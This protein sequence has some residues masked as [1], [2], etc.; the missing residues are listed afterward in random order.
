MV[1][2]KKSIL[3][4]ILLAGLLTAT[5]VFADDSNN[6]VQLDLKRASDSSVDVTLVT[7][8]NYGDNVMVR[9]KSDT[10][11]VI[12][13]PKVK[14]AGYRASNLTGVNDLVS[15]VD[16]KTVED[17]SGGYTKVTLITTRPLDIK[18]RTQKTNVSSSDRKEYNSLMAQANAVKNNVSKYEPPKQAQQKT[19]ITVNKTPNVSAKDNSKKAA[20]QQKP[21]IKLTEITPDKIEKQAKKQAKPN[22]LAQ[23][24]QEKALEELPKALPEIP[25]ILKNEND[26]TSDMP[27]EPI[28]TTNNSFNLKA[29]LAALY[30]KAA[31]KIPSKL[32]KAL[33]VG[34][35]ALITVSALAKLFGRV[36]SQTVLENPTQTFMDNISKAHLP[37]E[38]QTYDDYVTS[39]DLSWREKY[40][41]YLDKNAQP[42]KRANKKGHYSFIKMPAK[43]D[44]EKKRQ[45]LEKLV[46]K[47]EVT[48]Q[49]EHDFI[50]NVISEDT[51]ISRTVKFKA[52][53][54]KTNSLRM[55]S[56]DKSRF[57]GYETRL[58]LHELPNVDLEDSPLASN[59][60][61]LSGANLKVSDVDKRKI[62]YEP[63]EYIMSSVDEYLSILD[64][65]KEDKL[66]K[67][68]SY[69]EIS[70]KEEHMAKPVKAEKPEFLQGTV[71]KSGYKISPEKGIYM[72][73]KNGK[74]ALV[75]KINDKTFVLKKFDGMVSDPVRVRHDNANVYMVK[76][77][78]F[79]S[80]VE[81]DED[82]MGVLIEL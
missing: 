65:E 61:S 37:L 47:P 62:T 23:A 53:S 75:G 6:L 48:S 79:K 64:K 44:I 74:N 7:S 43:A 2:K 34:V 76:A 70:S 9:K 29:S 56:R 38:N 4:I 12:L 22:M 33:G 46:S 19:E 3:N 30:H 66:I 26:T 20:V 24:R 39:K 41:L 8:D 35:I 49:I 58:P 11:Y 5:S 67:E 27:L 77:G 14:S 82:K 50:N 59:T 80:L 69:T 42:V 18:T 28:Q 63:K 15:N 78:K 25:E 31:N 55:T 72:I 51:A 17:T 40:R 73:N 60:R 1:V 54:N 52:F 68:N 57:K 36:N 13:V 10:K 21:N 32:P 71:V 45:E 81:V 16:V